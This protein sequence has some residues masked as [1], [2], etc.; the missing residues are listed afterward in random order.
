VEGS[1]EAQGVEGPDRGCPVPGKG[2]LSIGE[3]REGRKRVRPLS[4]VCLWPTSGFPSVPIRWVLVVDP[5]GQSR[6]EA[7][8]ST[9]GSLAPEKIIA[10]HVMRWNVEVTFQEGRRHLGVE[11]QRQWS[12]Q[13][14]ARTTPVLPGVHSLVCRMAHRLMA[15]EQ[16]G[17]RST[18]WYVKEQE[19]FSDVLAFVR[20][21]IWA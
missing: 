21:G 2:D 6:A 11:T 1:Q 12:E 4:G 9:D 13:P 3:Y 5:T 17:I 19:T 16:I 14:I 8:F 18:V 15:D 7:F 20:R 10:H